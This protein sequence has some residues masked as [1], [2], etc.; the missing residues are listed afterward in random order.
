MKILWVSPTPSHPQSAGNRAHIYALGREV[1]HAGHEVTFLFYGQE[2]VDQFALAEM[3]SFWT[4]FVYVPHRHTR[5]VRSAGKH[6]GIDNWFND[7]I[8]LSARFLATQTRF[9]AVFCEYVFFSKVLTLF[10][11]KVLKVLNCH[12]RMSDRAEL[13]ARN[14]IAPD[15][16]YTTQA[17]EKIALD[18]ADLVLAIQREERDFFASLSDTAVIELGHPV[19]PGVSWQRVTGDKL[20][21]GYLGSNNSL[22]RKSVRDFIEALMHRP[23]VASKTELVLA[24][25]IGDAFQQEGVTCLGWVEDEAAFFRDIDLVVNPMVDGSGLKIKTLAA[26]RSGMP[27]LSTAIG[28]AGIPV[29]RV[30]HLCPSVPAM[31]DELAQHLGER[32]KW[33]NELKIQS[34]AVLE[35]YTARQNALLAQ[36]LYCLSAGSVRHLRKKRVLLVTDVPFWRAG[37]GSHARILELCQALRNR[38][39]LRVFFFASLGAEDRSLIAA[40]GLSDV[41]LSY[42]DYEEKAKTFSLPVKFPATPGL[43]KWRQ[44]FFSKCL[45]AYL[46]S[47]PK[48]DSVIFEYIWLAYTCDA[49]YYPALTVI[50]THDLMAPREFRFRVNGGTAGVSISLA[51]EIA[52]LDRFDAV[53]AIQ[54]E[55]ARALAGM[56]KRAIPLCC[57]H[58]VSVSDD[59]IEPERGSG[60][61][62]LGFIGAG[63]DANFEAIDWFL[64]QVWPIVAAEPVRLHVFGDVCARLPTSLEGVT[65]HGKVDFVAHAYG[66]CDVMIN[67]VIHGGGIKIKSVESLVFGLP[68]IASAEGAVGIAEPHESG[69]IVAKSRGEFVDAIL[70]LIHRP[71]V[72]RQMAGQARSAGKRQ[73]NPETCFEPVIA[74][75]ESY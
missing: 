75:I 62:R 16:F 41:V 68:L 28:T 46:R 49:L 71:A 56:L 52:L 23:E 59:G 45:A 69:V 33:L 20:R 60:P 43:G 37:M 48:F 14:G 10:D 74:M 38:F 64:K 44:N 47:V 61:L 73:F 27:F 63:N 7:D 15:F 30:E 6:W 55:E 58:G 21:L 12:D 50:D 66:Q 42:K 1:M 29:S 18:R 4:Q 57:P 13:L 26:I 9:D 67:P 40:L 70:S 5:R 22:N 31:V 65:L 53:V 72:R 24:G 35:A 11:K 34:L 17:Q 36:F 19:E 25:S 39:A 32:E 54:H 51:E 3:R 2:V 8:A